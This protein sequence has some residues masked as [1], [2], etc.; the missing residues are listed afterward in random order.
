[1]CKA[2]TTNPKFATVALPHLA[3]GLR[4]QREAFLLTNI[5]IFAKVSARHLALAM[6][7]RGFLML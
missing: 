6:S 5:S 4:E 2:L 7:S 1:M 3:L